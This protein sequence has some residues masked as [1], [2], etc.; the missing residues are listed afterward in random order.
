ML[1]THFLEMTRSRLA[2]QCLVAKQTSLPS[3]GEVSIL[4]AGGPL[5]ALLMATTRQVYPVAGL[6][7]D[8]L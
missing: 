5:P 7:P 3:S 4:S 1:Y 8:S 6:N 2:L